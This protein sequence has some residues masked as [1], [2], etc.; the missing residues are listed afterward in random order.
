MTRPV[1]ATKKPAAVELTEGETYY[2]CRCGRSKSQP[3][4]DG[5]HASTDITPLEFTAEKTGKAFLCQCKGT[6]N[7]PFCDG[8][9]SRLDADAGSELPER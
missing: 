1:I 8:A 2:W 5:S 9:H 4:C 7:Q 6:A 3:F